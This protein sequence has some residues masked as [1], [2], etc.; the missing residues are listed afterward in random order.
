MEL[1]GYSF[2]DIYDRNKPPDLLDVK[3]TM[4][5]GFARSIGNRFFLKGTNI[6][7]LWCLVKSKGLAYSQIDQQYRCKH[8]DKALLC[9]LK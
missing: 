4:F 2:N 6:E 9:P 8:G 5:P 7:A 3:S 1:L